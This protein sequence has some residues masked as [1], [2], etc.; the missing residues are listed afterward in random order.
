[1]AVLR[2]RAADGTWTEVPALVGPKGDT[3]ERG[4][5]GVQGVQG[6]TGPM[7]PTGPAGPTGPEGPQGI[8][9][10]AGPTGP[11]GPQG[12]KGDTG[13]V[14]YS[15]LEGY[16]PVAHEHS[17]GDITSGVLPL[18]RGGI[19]AALS[20][21][22]NAIVRCSSNSAKFSLTNTASGALY[23]TESKGAPKFGT[24]PIA[25]GGTGATDAATALANI[26][27]A[28]AEHTHDQYLTEH[29]DLS[30]YAKKADIPTV[31]SMTAETWT[32]TLEDGSTV[33]KAVYLA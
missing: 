11:E 7:G 18:S 21:S 17:A 9:G 13:E 27:A 3:G 22:A 30:A 16:A 14:D 12:P 29:Q 8:Q 2:V 6:E 24:L 19:G 33:T 10:P 4:P 20:V 1:M 25:Q 5:E 26:G 15:V 31:P 32:F 23:A 28:A